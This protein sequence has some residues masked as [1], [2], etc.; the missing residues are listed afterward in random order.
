MTRAEELLDRE[1]SAIADKWGPAGALPVTVDSG[2]SGW[3]FFG[4]ATY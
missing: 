4:F 2:E 3:L 1:D